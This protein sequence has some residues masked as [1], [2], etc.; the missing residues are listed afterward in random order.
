MTNTIQRP[1]VLLVI[2]LLFCTAGFAQDNSTKEGEKPSAPAKAVA[3]YKVEIKLVEIEKGV[4]VNERSFSLM[5]LENDHTSLRAGTRVPVAMGA[6]GSFQYMDV[7]LNFN[8]HVYEKDGRLYGDF[9]IHI[10]S[11]A[12]PEQETTVKDNPLL[13]NIDQNVSGICPNG[14]TVLLTS[15]DDQTS[16][17]TIQVEVTVTKM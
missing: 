16:K 10:T 14:K 12:L 5:S 3:Q 7:G 9:G 13:R 11:F 4:R 15:M 2:I 8:I 17:K 6:G 1:A